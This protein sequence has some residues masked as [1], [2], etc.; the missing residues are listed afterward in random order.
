M[1]T[2]A[3]ETQVGVQ[4]DIQYHPDYQK[5][6]ARTQRRKATE[7]LI[8]TLPPGFPAQLSSPLVWEG[9]DIES[10][11]DWIYKLSEEQL[12]EIDAA[13]KHFQCMS[14]S[15]LHETVQS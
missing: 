11:D 1:S 2:T 9:K 4:P 6:K 3:V 15:H 7:D 13:L 10:R 8:Q 12:N 5:Y 14:T